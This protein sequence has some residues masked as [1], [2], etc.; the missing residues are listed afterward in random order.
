MITPLDKLKAYPTKSLDVRMWGKLQL[1]QLG[2]GPA[3]ACDVLDAPICAQ[4]H[5][6][7]DA[8][9]AEG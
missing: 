2:D 9:L 3:V 8:M 6:P 7:W 1:A 5:A 4:S